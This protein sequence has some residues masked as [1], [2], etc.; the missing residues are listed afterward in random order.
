MLVKEVLT[1]LAR[2]QSG[3]DSIKK[4]NLKG[5]PKWVKDGVNPKAVLGSVLPVTLTRPTAWSFVRSQ[6]L[7]PAELRAHCV[8][9]GLQLQ[10]VTQRYLCHAARIVECVGQFCDW[11]IVA[12]SRC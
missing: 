11:G 12:A 2:L 10:F 3:N 1:A 4:G 8:F 7:Y 6:T 5:K 9:S